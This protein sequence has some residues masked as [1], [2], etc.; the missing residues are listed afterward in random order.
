M[1]PPA[2]SRTARRNRMRRNYIAGEWIEA[3]NAT[4]FVLIAALGCVLGWATAQAHD[5]NLTRSWPR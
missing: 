3:L 5:V 2:G 4:S 1:V